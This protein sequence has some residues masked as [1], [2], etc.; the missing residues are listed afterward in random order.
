MGIRNDN[1]GMVMVMVLLF[2][3]ATILIGIFMMRST[4]IETKIVTNEKE[5]NQNFY[6]AESAA[7]I[8]LPQFDDIVSAAT[9][10]IDNRVDISDKM[11]AG[12]ALDGAEVGITLRRVGN[13]PVGSGASATKTTAY[14]YRVDATVGDEKV[15]MG[16]WKAFPKPGS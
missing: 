13:P 9:W 7:E 8:V 3:L 14:Y 6:L 15:E 12:S 5:H 11:P 1:S 4:I 16:L 10:T 2:M